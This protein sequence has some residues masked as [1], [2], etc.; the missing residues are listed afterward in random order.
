MSTQGPRDLGLTW[1]EA[2]H[3]VQSATAHEQNLGSSSGTPKYLRTGVNMA[4][5]DHGALVRLLIA[6]GFITEE[7]YLEAVRLGANEE[8]ARHQ[9]LHPGITFR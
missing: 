2:A 8:L 4:M 3:G 1:E 6:K 9:D 5:A 7:E